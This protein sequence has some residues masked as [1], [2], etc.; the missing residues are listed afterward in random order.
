MAQR[1]MF[2]LQVFDSDEFLAMP[3][4]TQALYLHLALRA[5]DDGFL[6][7]PKRIIRSIGSSEDEMKLLIAKG[8]VIP[9]ESGIC[10]IRHWRIHNYI[11]SDRYHETTHTDE[12]AMLTLA[13]NGEYAVGMTS[14]IP[15][16]NQP[17]HQLDTEVRLGKDR[18]GKG[19]QGCA[20]A[21]DDLDDNLTAYI[22]TNLYTPTSGNW[23]ALREIM[24]DGMSADMVKAAVDA[25]NA[26]NARTLSYVMTI[27]NRWLVAGHRTPE[28][29]KAAEAKRQAGKDQPTVKQFQRMEDYADL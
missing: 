16:V 4:S 9:F 14:G 22:T 13:S 26:Q 25:A 29:V 1:R 8:Y 12:K 24:A 7:N 17:T 20:Y 2:S 21:R 27:L 11:R 23:E 18:L 28:D 10:V 3:L 15:S 19:S 5:D 6:N